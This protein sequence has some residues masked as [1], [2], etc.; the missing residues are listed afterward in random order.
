MEKERARK[1]RAK[2]REPQRRFQSL[3]N[4]LRTIQMNGPR[5]MPRMVEDCPHAFFNLE[6]LVDVVFDLVF[7][8]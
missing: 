8:T 7:H 5:L 3:E 2:E 6:E 1:E 4:S